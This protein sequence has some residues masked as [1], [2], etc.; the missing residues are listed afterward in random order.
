MKADKKI[1][2]RWIKQQN[3]ANRSSTLS[4]A[5]LGLINVGAG[6]VQAWALAH[7]LADFLLHQHYELGRFFA[8]FV[9]AC[10]VRVLLGAG[11]DMVALVAGQKARRTL[12]R[13]TLDRVFAY[14]PSLLR[15]QHSAAIAT[16]LVERVEALDGY[17]SRWL[18][19]ST[20]WPIAQW[21]VVAVVL[22]ENLHAGL[23]LAGC[24]LML[25]VFQAVF[26]IATAIASRRQF[27]AMGRLQTRFL[28]RI[29]GIATIVL[30][31]NA[32]R[33]AQALGN[34]AEELRKRTMKVL[35]VAFLTSATTDIMMIVALV[36]IV[37]S[38]SHSLL[39]SHSVEQAGA[40][41][42]AVL[43]VPE[44]FAP[45]RAFSAVYQ[46]RAQATATAEAMQ[47]V[48]QADKRAPA[49]SGELSPYHDERGIALVAQDVS[50]SWSSDRAPALTDVSFSLQSGETLL[51]EGPSGAGKSTLLELLLGFIT[52][53]EGKLLL[54]GCDMAALAA[55]DIS[56]HVSWIGQKPV[57]FAGTLRENI[58]FARPDAQ[59][60]ELKRALEASQV[61]RYLAQ[62]PDGLDTMI[63]EGGF[64]LS[65]GQAQRIAI[66]RAFLKDTPL[67]VMDEPTAHLDPAT[68]DELCKA[69]E[70]LL[71]G[72]TTII[73]THSE[74]IASLRR[75]QRIRLEGGHIVSQESVS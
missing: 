57:L 10:L 14:G 19:A 47:A 64:G 75:A 67:L 39:H 16:L 2:K 70:D 59:E 73:A 29:R 56:R 68:E 20:L 18:P 34:A 33:D 13:M 28:D 32:E 26:G 50:Y 30:S 71:H 44:A 58:L 55:S 40:A 3:R 17:F 52:P 61:G 8:V 38:Q 9:A 27:L 41:L 74:K 11:Q 72:R 5:L 36:W 12:R 15:H 54:G 37:I 66:A 46:D 6:V 24:C 53:Q 63:G 7:M 65:G 35:R 23:I 25:P 43:M 48:P 45:F 22:W 51:V 4:S 1:L 31:G 42:F 60:N 49:K 62:L 21:G 69:F